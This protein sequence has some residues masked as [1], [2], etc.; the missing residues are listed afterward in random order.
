SIPGDKKE[1][2]NIADFYY[3]DENYL[4]ILDIPL[5]QGSNFSA[6]N[7]VT[8]DALISSSG[9]KKLQAFSG[10]DNVVGEQLRIS[11]HGNITVR[12]IFPDFIINTIAQPDNRPAVFFYYPQSKF[13]EVRAKHSSFSFYILIK[14]NKT[15]EAGML[16][17]ITDTFNRFLPNSDAVVKSL[18]EQQRIGYQSEKGFRNAMMA[19]NFVIL[20]ITIIGLIGYTSTEA[21]RRRKEL[22]IRR[23]NGAALSDILKNFIA[24]IELI[25]IPAVV[26]G[27]IGAWFTAN[28]WMQDFAV[29]VPLSWGIFLATSMF[30][31]LLI[32]LVA[33]ANYTRTANRNPVEALR[34]E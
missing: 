4:S 24:N 14:A 16:A 3:I 26:L 23:I 5:E 18:E 30:V 7:A 1:L 25:A 29:K 22:A 32:A 28:K 6:Q 27:L 2:F 17:T 8:G 10:W 11:E 9:A 21:A 34:Y 15:A 20:L 31:L 19:G 12:G 33:A 13:E